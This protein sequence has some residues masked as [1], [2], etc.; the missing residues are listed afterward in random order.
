M[1]DLRWAALTGA[2][3]ISASAWAKI[4]DEIKPQLLAAARSAGERLQ[5]RIRPLEDEAVSAMQRHGLVVHTVSP[6]IAADWERRA[7]AGYPKLMGCLVPAKI[8][9]EAERL[10][11]E[12]RAKSQ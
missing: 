7:R 2:T 11:D 8:V 12:Y 1:T 9:A 5:H 4:P 10:R 3:V 6:E